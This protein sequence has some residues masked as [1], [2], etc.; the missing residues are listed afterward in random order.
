[1]SK[2]LE[3]DSLSKKFT[4]YRNRPF[5]LKESI[6]RRFKGLNEKATTIWALRNVSFSVEQ[7][8]AFGIIGH[9]GA[10]KSTLLRLLC[11]LGRPTSGSI[12]RFGQV[13]GLL[14]L[15][16]GFHPDMTG[17][18]NIM[19]GGL[20]NGLTVAEVREREDE[21]IS[22]A[23]LEEFIDQPLRTYSSGMY[24]RLA[25]ATAMNFDPDL[26]V[27]DEVL[28][29][30]DS[31]FQQ[32]CYET[33]QSFR[34]DGKTL[35]LTTHD[36]DQIR[37]VC[38]EVLVLEDGIALMQGKPEDA[39][40]CYSDL[41]RQRSERRSSQL[42]GKVST[43]IP[44]LEQGKRFGTQEATIDSVKLYNDKKQI[45]NDIQSYGS[46]T[47]ELKYQVFNNI[48]DMVLTMG[49]Y[50]DLNI[51]CF[52]TQVPSI[53]EAFGPL[54]KVGVVSCHIPE[55]PLLPGTY[56]INIG[57]YPLTWN[58][59]YDFHW[60]M[61]SFEVTSGNGTQPNVSGIV[62]IEPIWS[63]QEDGYQEIK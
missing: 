14:E 48:P 33:L 41:M 51:K 55:L 59:V 20:L 40:N 36:M 47:M 38:S 25:F 2:V 27:I 6:I 60:Q 4:V 3:I 17:R 45:I 23:E 50:S 19:T 13:S 35:I 8:Q 32:K 11:G 29:V 56:Y 24:L 10:G 31:R 43:Q 58:Y 5:T 1:M 15:G 39:I 49:I 9:N 53:K 63:I 61:H 54:G 52:E 62:S 16:S 28:T 42:T 37:K 34:N 12:R 22:F 46:L 44:A 30:G 7:G 18:E 26:L 21:I 57:L